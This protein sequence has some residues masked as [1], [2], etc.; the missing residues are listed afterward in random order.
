MSTKFEPEELE[1]ELNAKRTAWSIKLIEQG[2]PVL[3]TGTYGRVFA[4]TVRGQKVAIKSM[5]DSPEI[6]KNPKLA[7]VFMN[8]ANLQESA[9]KANS[10]IVRCLGVCCPTKEQV[11]EDGATF[12]IVMERM[13]GPTLEKAIRN[14]G[15]KFPLPP[16]G[17]PQR[18]KFVARIGL[19]IVKALWSLQ[20]MRPPIYLLD[21]KPQNLIFKQP[22]LLQLS[23]IDLG[24]A[25]VADQLRATVGAQSKVEVGKEHGT[26]GYMDPQIQLTGLANSASDIFS[27]ASVLAYC[28]DKKAQHP[29]FGYG[30]TAD[31]AR[32]KLEKGE[33]M[34]IDSDAD[35]RLARIIRE[36]WQLD[37]KQR[38][39]LEALI[40]KL[41]QIA[42]ESTSGTAADALQEASAKMESGGVSVVLEFKQQLAEFIALLKSQPMTQIINNNI[43]N[44][45]PANVNN[46]AVDNSTHH[47][48]HNNNNAAAAASSQAIPETLT[49]PPE[50]AEALKKQNARLENVEVMDLST[51]NISDLSHLRS[52]SKLKSL[53]RRAKLQHR[54]VGNIA[55]PELDVFQVDE[56]QRFAFLQTAKR[57]ELDALTITQ[58]EFRQM[59]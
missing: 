23:L 55:V 59:R 58:H 4:G 17:T 38:P 40:V 14:E 47:T 9:S 24:S 35:P 11:E 15:N 16:I 50:I 30:V 1:V 22:D 25:R 27:F 3:G 26:A 29:S 10:A 21:L 5:K 33:Q 56:L 45:G 39:T 51:T 54:N 49:I 28:L 32:K 37:H 42:Y 7:A 19:A 2:G 43:T 36:C 41:S 12:C 44:I 57:V 13:N 48:T 18:T 52:C 46:A 34:P 6:A 53:N 8:E 31:E 20:G